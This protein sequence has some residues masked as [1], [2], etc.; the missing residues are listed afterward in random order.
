MDT[1]VQRQKEATEQLRIGSNWEA[2]VEVPAASADRKHIPSATLIRRELGNGGVLCVRLVGAPGSGKTSLI[3]A[4]LRYCN[5]PLRAV[6]LLLNSN[7]E[8][9]VIRFSKSDVRS[10]LI[11]NDLPKAL[12][13][14]RAISQ[15]RLGDLDIILLEERG[16]RTPLLDLGQDA[17]VAV[18]SITDSDNAA[19][20]YRSMI[21]IASV[22]V[23]TKKDRLPLVEFDARKFSGDVRSINAEALLHELS[24]IN[25][26]G[27]THFVNWLQDM[28][29][30][31]RGL[32]SMFGTKD[33]VPAELLSLRK[34]IGLRFETI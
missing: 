14:W 5:P 26:M 13:V 21:E 29:K 31:K 11:E 33:Q 27:V 19:A 12:A 1:D 2:N 18:V 3:E 24:A 8:N 10:L 20:Q 32:D 9:H 15:L 23:L 16:G 6:H 17:T 34:E 25:G 7:S 30:Q 28:Q 4:A 22:V